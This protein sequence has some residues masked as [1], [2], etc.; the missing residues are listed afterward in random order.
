M[1]T[2]AL[3]GKHK[4]KEYTPCCDPV[5]PSWLNSVY[6]WLWAAPPI[7]PSPA[8][9]LNSRVLRHSSARAGMA[10]TEVALA[11]A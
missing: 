7:L 5:L 11:M 10:R 3:L 6:R 8:A 1:A 4:T 2:T 9:D